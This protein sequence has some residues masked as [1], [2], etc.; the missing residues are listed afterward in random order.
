[1]MKLHILEQFTYIS[2]FLFL[3]LYRQNGITVNVQNHEL[4]GRPVDKPITD[5]RLYMLIVIIMFIWLMLK[6]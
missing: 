3:L 1:M 4:S 6:A 2:F 5:T